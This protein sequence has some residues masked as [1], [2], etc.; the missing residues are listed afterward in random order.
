M[1]LFQW[2][3]ELSVGYPEIDS[4]H[5]MLFKYADDLH[6]AML[7]GKGKDI[8]GQTLADLIAY[9][10]RHFA[11][12]ERLMQTHQY[13]DYPPH[14]AEH[15][16]LTQEVVKLQQDFTSSRVAL[17]GEIMKFLSDWL[18]HHIG[19]IDKKAG[20]YLQQQAH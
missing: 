15:D 19:E 20:R 18:N 14:K 12:E 16:A 6:S 11:A 7:S 3:E 9:T 5:K 4:Q 8:L 1:S 2:K 17:T 13:P 10:K